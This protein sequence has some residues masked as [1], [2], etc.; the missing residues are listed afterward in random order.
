MLSYVSRSCRRKETATVCIGMDI[1]CVTENV[2]LTI[3]RQTEAHR[4][5]DKEKGNV[6]ERG[7]RQQRK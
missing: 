4:R 7:G 1:S 5:G 2:I 3:K 6:E